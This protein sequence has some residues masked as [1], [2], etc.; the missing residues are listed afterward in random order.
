MNPDELMRFKGEFRALAD[1][2]HANLVSLG[3]LIEEGGQWF[4]TMELVEGTPFD[5]YVWI[6]ADDIGPP[7]PTSNMTELSDAGDTGAGVA[8]PPAFP[9][10]ISGHLLT[11]TARRR[12][13]RR[14]AD[15]GGQRAD[16][17]ARRAQSRSRYGDAR[18]LNDE[19]KP[20]RR[21]RTL[22]RLRLALELAL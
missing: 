4:F 15:S 5:E 10:D 11:R 2:A 9:T 7:V 17:R 13:R 16:R 6:A 14:R 3:E 8:V 20:P 12:E 21:G 22:R 1:I 18:A 19:P